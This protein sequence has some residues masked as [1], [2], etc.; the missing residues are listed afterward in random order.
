MADRI[1]IMAPKR[2]SCPTLTMLA[3][4]TPGRVF[5]LERKATTLGRDVT[6]DVVLTPSNVSRRHARIERRAGGYV[7]EDLGSSAG[8]L[9]NE[10]ALRGPAGLRD[11]DRIRI[12]ECLL[13]FSAPHGGPG[14][15]P[16]GAA[17]RTTGS[18]A[19]PPSA[20]RCS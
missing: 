1:P 9:V 5:A 7:L 4:P 6:C 10:V 15:S 12:G 3:G 20:R 18:G 17:S 13:A 14:A 16:D 2:T 19:G 8:T 11:G